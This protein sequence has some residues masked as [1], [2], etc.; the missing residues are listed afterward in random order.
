VPLD[1]FNSNLNGAECNFTGTGASKGNIP[2]NRAAAGQCFDQQK[3]TKPKKN[4]QA[5]G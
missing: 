2:E 3:S 1:R 4:S 5:S